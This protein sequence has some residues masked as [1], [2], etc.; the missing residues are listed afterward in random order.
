MHLVK[1][2]VIRARILTVCLTSITFHVYE[3][4]CLAL[5]TTCV[6]VWFCFWIPGQE[7]SKCVVHIFAYNSMDLKKTFTHN[8]K[9]IIFSFKI[10]FYL[11]KTVHRIFVPWSAFVRERSRSCVDT[12]AHR[13]PNTRGHHR[14]QPQAQP[15][16]P[17][18]WCK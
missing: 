10:L 3:L 8:Q 16:Q 1:S 12:P 5:D 9:S 6:L 11:I 4:G 14:R 17:C 13:P 2:T 15:L 7:S 18:W